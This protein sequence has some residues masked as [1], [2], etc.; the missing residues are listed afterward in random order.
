[1]KTNIQKKLLIPC[2]FII[3]ISSIF[4]A[5]KPLAWPETIDK[6]IEEILRIKKEAMHFPSMRSENGVLGR[7][8]QALMDELGAMITD[9]E[10]ISKLQANEGRDIK[11]KIALWAS[12][13]KER[14]DEYARFAKYYVNE[15]EGDEVIA[16]F[17]RK[18]QGFVTDPDPFAGPERP[19]NSVPRPGTWSPNPVDDED[20]KEEFRLILEYHYFVPPTGKQFDRDYYLGQ[21]STALQN[22]GNYSKSLIVWIT[23]AR[24]AI[25]AAG[26]SQ[27]TEFPK[28]NSTAF[29]ILT[30][31]DSPE[32]FSALALFWKNGLSKGIITKCFERKFGVVNT[33]DSN[34]DLKEYNSWIGLAKLASLSVDER[35][36]A[37]WLLSLDPPATK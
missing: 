5:E 8:S 25:K 6:K 26:D 12:D 20:Q 7:R 18:P 22:I 14:P 3:L 21:I 29:V 33:A 36:F 9:P 28:G 35:E 16:Y 2:V 31:I 34:P 24:L 11:A 37:K 30:S 15:P 10:L 27:L 4:A 13:R 19:E 32:S 17:W 23:D 1:M